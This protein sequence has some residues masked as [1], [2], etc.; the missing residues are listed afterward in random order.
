[1]ARHL[2]RIPAAHP[3]L[4]CAFVVLVG[5]FE[6]SRGAVTSIQG[7]V[8]A[9]LQE[10]IN[11]G[12][13]DAVDVTDD[14]PGTTNQFPLIAIA[15]LLSSASSGAGS[16]A[17]QLADPTTSGGLNPQEFAL[18]LAISSVDGTRRFVGA[19]KATEVRDIVFNETDFIGAQTGDTVQVQ[20]RVW[21]DGALSIF[22]EDSARD[23]TGAVVVVR[24]RVVQSSGGEVFTGD[25]RLDGG[26]AGSAI[27]SR[28][29]D[30][31][32]IISPVA[33][34]GDLNPDF[35]VVWIATIP[36]VFVEYNYEAV[37][38]TPFTLTATYE[39]DATNLPD[40]VGCAAV[41][42]TPFETLAQVVALTQSEP[43]AARI[44]QNISSKRQEVNAR[45]QPAL[46]CPLAG[47]ALTVIPLAA[48][49]MIGLSG[50]RARR[51]GH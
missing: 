45:S 6:S 2:P 16:A 31:Q 20:G 4:L 22:S 21:I 26:G 40:G 23:L 25:V 9:T 12:G 32:N 3:A 51:R 5:G 43:A 39:L 13:G 33:D 10:S 18:N 36:E 19:A 41:I 50:A 7:S 14:L 27:R 24:V 15:Q 8:R 44:A 34:L 37:I 46:L 11:D 35:A 30:F 42:G 38:G 49:S 29:G 28:S 1:M 47:A 17:A 48:V